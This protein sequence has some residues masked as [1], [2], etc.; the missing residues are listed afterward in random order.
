[1]S[2][3][4]YTADYADVAVIA[5]KAETCGFSNIAVTAIFEGYDIVIN[6]KYA[7]KVLKRAFLEHNPGQPDSE[8][9]GNL[10]DLPAEIEL[11]I[12]ADLHR[13]NEVNNL[14]ES[15]MHLDDGDGGHL[16]DTVREYMYKAKMGLV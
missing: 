11:V 10:K 16:K 2:V 3:I 12:I 7:M 15:D 9:L 1:M 13:V 8:F 14:I 5:M 4:A 6:D